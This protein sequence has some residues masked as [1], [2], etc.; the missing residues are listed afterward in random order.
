ARVRVHLTLYC[1]VSSRIEKSATFVPDVVFRGRVLRAD[2]RYDHFVVEHVAG[3]GGDL[4]KLIGSAA[5]DGLH[6]WRPSLER[7]LLEKANAAIV[8]AGDTKEV[9]ISLAKLLQ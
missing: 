7:R 8:K 5:Q 9:R 4:A 6:R 2:L 3:V 1:E